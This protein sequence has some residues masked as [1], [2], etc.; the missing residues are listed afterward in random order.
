MEEGR[1]S[2]KIRTGIPVGKRPLGRLRSRWKDNTKIEL[3]EI[4]VS[5]RNSVVS[6]LDRNYL[7]ALVNTALN[8]RV[9]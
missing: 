2:I 9:P 4:G 3:K 5:A 7:R 8:L 6:A 1:S